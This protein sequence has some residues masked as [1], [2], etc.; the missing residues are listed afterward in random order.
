MRLLVLIVAFAHC[1]EPTHAYDSEVVVVRDAW[2]ETMGADECGFPDVAMQRGLGVG[3]Y[4]YA[5]DIVINAGM[6]DAATRYAVRHETVHWLAWCT[7][8]QVSGDAGH[9]MTELWGA[10]GVLDR[11]GAEQ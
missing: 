10:G 1:P 7:G 9:S 3:G 5:N 11:A 8:Y 2:A 4:H 6:D